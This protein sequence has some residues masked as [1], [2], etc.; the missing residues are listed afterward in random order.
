MTHLGT[1]MPSEGGHIIKA[2]PKRSLPATQQQAKS[3]ASDTD[4][5]R[6]CLPAIHPKPSKGVSDLIQKGT[7]LEPP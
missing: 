5:T 4:R 2:V 1:L 6:S 7:P 3:R